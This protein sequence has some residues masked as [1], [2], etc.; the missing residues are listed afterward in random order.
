VVG[1]YYEVFTII[2]NCFFRVKPE[3]LECISVI[4][5][6]ILKILPGLI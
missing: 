1:E 3:K 5:I 2:C 4:I 6:V